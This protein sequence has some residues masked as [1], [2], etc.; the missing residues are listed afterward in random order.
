MFVEVKPELSVVIPA[1]NEAERIE[2]T[3]ND[4]LFSDRSLFGRPCELLIV[5]DGCTDGT[6]EIVEQ[7]IGDN[8]N[9]SALVFPRRLGKGGAIMEALKCT[10]GD[11]IAFIDA[12][13]S[14]PVS[15][16]RR[17]IDLTDRY[18]LV[19]GSRYDKDSK[20]LRKRP[21][22]RTLLSRSFNVLERIMFWSLSQVKDTQCGVK[23]FSKRLVDA[24][25][26][27][28]LIT[29]FAFDVNIIYSSLSFGFK[30]KEVG[31]SW[32]EKEGSKLSGG[33][34][35]HSVKMIFSLIR[36]RLYYSRFRKVLYSPRFEKL[37]RVFYS[38]AKA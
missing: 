19:I 29:D 6:P 16:L 27:D 34:A 9:A 4:L 33:F 30:V 7:F 32:F 21:L 23:V 37:G 13:G 22:K 18:D 35:K 1:Y 15:E 31:I 11:V 5:M 38:W 28:F 14:V 24:I 8:P 36:L 26:N 12:D 25:R 10:R 20:I 3:L 17:L 2:T